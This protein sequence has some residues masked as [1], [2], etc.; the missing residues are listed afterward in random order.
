VAISLND[1]AA[2]STDDV[3]AVGNGT[4]SEDAD[5]TDPAFEHWD[6][7]S[8]R[9]VPGQRTLEDEEEILGVDAVGANDI[10]AVGSVGQRFRDDRQIEIQ[11]WDGSAWSFVSPFQAS[12]NN[13]LEGV[14]TVSSDDV[15][16][17]GS[18][19]TGGGSRDRSLVEHWNGSSWSQIPIPDPA[20]SDFLKKVAVVSAEDVW[21]VGSQAPPT[22]KLRP[23]AM[24][25]NGSRWSVVPVPRV[26]RDSR[27]TDVVAI[28]PNDVWAVGHAFEPSIPSMSR[29]L[30]EHWD[31][32]A[33]RIVRSPDTGRFNSDELAAVTAISTG[34]VWGIG[35]YVDDGEK[36]LAEHWDG[37]SWSIVPAPPSFSMNDVAAVATADVWAVGWMI[38]E[39]IIEHWD[40]A[41]WSV[42]PSP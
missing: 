21:A 34:D 27:F 24:H 5:N 12:I 15:W 37:A 41:S 19:E 6:G 9:L 20:G 16:A 30:T 4:D 14:A 13:I 8:W 38:S 25:W 18:M 23:L 39:S 2:V 40:G 32:S 35:N 31:G 28:G 29:P 1:V 26:N 36:T 10:W 7:T 11:H 33:W 42:V 17:V 22:G 3:W